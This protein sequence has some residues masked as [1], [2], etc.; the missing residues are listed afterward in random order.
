MRSITSRVLKVSA[1][2]ALAL[3]FFIPAG[4]ALAGTTGAV[5]PI[6]VVDDA[7]NTT[8]SPQRSWLSAGSA[9][10]LD[11]VFAST[12]RSFNATTL[13]TSFLRAGGFDFS[14]IP[15]DATIN[16]VT[17][18]IVKKGVSFVSD[19]TQG[20]DT[21][22]D[23]QLYLETSSATSSNKADTATTWN[24]STAVASTYSGGNAYWG[25]TLTPAVLKSS[26]FNVLFSAQRVA[27][28]AIPNVDSISVTV[29]YTGEGCNGSS[30]DSSSLGSVNGQGGWTS[31]G[32]FD[33]AV[34]TNTYG[35]STFGCKTLRMSDSVTSGS[36]GNQT[37]SYSI[38]NEAGESTALNEGM[39]GGVRQNHFEAQFD[40]ASALPTLQ[41]GMHFSVSPDR[42]DGARMSY[43]RLEDQADGIHV[44]FDDVQGQNVGFQAANFVETAIATIDRNPHTLKFSMDLL[45]GASNDVVKIYIDGALVH[46]GTSWENYYRF[47]TESQGDPHNVS[48]ENKSRTVD[49]LLFRESGSAHPGNAG[50]GFLIDN[51][52]LSSSIVPTATILQTSTTTTSN[53]VTGQEYFVTWSSTNVTS[54]NL[55][56][57]TSTAGTGINTSWDTGLSGSRSQ[58][59]IKLGEF[60]YWID[61]V[62]PYGE[63]HDEIIHYVIS[64]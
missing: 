32:P 26:G 62:G 35:F 63:A 9:T 50:R 38:A 31:T 54:C 41:S 52:A 23:Y 18:T 22:A 30:F 28:N 4:L 59:T 60:H 47:D 45:D 44:F 34:V 19:P 13:T 39:S 6:G 7:S 49:A 3:G 56:K 21:A 5:Y 53:G 1:S 46:T 17:V 64:Q 24:T 48:Y 2:A 11:G 16:S 58:A 14:S 37:F 42:G 15:N 12:T 27:Q 57:T 20:D 8:G 10:A 61:C 40:V 43:L 55:R 51:V 36:F 29:N 33:Q 25:M